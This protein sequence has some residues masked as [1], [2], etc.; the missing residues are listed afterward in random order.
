MKN[1]KQLLNNIIGQFK[2][3]SKMMDEERICEDVI[4]QLKAVKSATNV[5]ISKYVEESAL[6]CLKKESSIKEKDKKEIKKLLKELI[7]NN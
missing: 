6:T 7:N 5:L 4:T 3:I 1:S 2:G